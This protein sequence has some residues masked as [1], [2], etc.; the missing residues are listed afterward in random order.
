MRRWSSVAR[1]V[2]LMIAVTARAHAQEG[3]TLVMPFENVTR[4]GRI[5]WLGEAAAVLLTDELNELGLDAITRDERRAA[6]R[7]LQVP[8]NVALTDATVFRIGQLVGATRVIVG[9]LRLDGDALVVR[10]RA[11][12]LDSARVQG[13]VTDRGPMP[14][15]FDTFE[16]VARAIAPGRGPAPGT[17]KHPPVAAFENYIKGL[18][19]ATPATAIQYLNAALRADATF[20]RARLALWTVYDEQGDHTR[21][22]ATVATITQAAAAY[23]RARFLVGLSQMNLQRYDDAFATFKTLADAGSTAALQNNLGVIQLRRGGS[24]DAGTAAYY[25]TRAAEADATESDFC[26]NLGYAY[27]FERDTAA[28]VYWL[29]E[30][31]RRDPTDGDAHY[32]LGAALTLAGNTSEAAREKELARRLSSAYADWDKRPAA[33]PIPSGLERI[34][35]D[36]DLPH[37]SRLGENIASGGQRDQQELARFYLE[38]GRRL[39]AQEHD[40]EALAELNRAVFLSPYEAEA[41]LWVGRIHLRGGR[42]REAI[43]ALKISLWSSETAEA[44]AVLGEAYLEAKEFDLART[45]AERALTLDA[46]SAVARRVLDRLPR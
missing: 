32:V 23:R 29:R 43:D 22:L 16:R 5:V 41:H 46:A 40:G 36:M 13:D 11:I 21:A 7:Q 9:T 42:L 33:D 3:R 6:L 44:H 30:A 26:F 18:L 39:F 35:D 25:F 10:A 8:P 19:A 37:A 27:F 31:V 12:V 17:A 1:F 14:E 15:I 45:E 38:R 28:A 24:R 34:K 20:D 2:A 4:E